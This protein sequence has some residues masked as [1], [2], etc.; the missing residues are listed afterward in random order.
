MITKYVLNK[1]E[2]ERCNALPVEEKEAILKEI[3]KIEKKYHIQLERIRIL[4]GYFSEVDEKEKD[5]HGTGH[6]KERREEE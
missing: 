3:D 1:K 5:V 6:Q 4:K 2:K